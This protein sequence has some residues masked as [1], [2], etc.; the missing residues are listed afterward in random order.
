MNGI[1]RHAAHRKQV[2]MD[3]YLHTKPEH[4]PAQK[5]AALAILVWQADMLFD[6]ERLGRR[7]SN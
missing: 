7:Y 4:H 5:S 1:V 6:V 2:Q 3:V